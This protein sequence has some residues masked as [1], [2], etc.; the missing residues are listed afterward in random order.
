MDIFILVLEL[1]GAGWGVLA[2]CA[3]CLCI[4]CRFFLFFC[5]L[6]RKDRRSPEILTDG[7]AR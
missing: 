4:K 3:S 1:I 6:S 5:R 2:A 7:L